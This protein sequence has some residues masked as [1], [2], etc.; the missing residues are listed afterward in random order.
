MSIA[1]NIQYIKAQLPGNVRLVCVSKFHPV[2]A[3]QE[4]YNAGQRVF[5]ESKVQEMDEKHEAL[6]KDIEWHFIG[7][8]QSNKIKYIVPYVTLIHGVDSK[9]LLIE[10]NKQAEKIGRKVNCLLQVYIAQEE[11]KFGFLSEEVLSM[12]ESNTLEELPYVSVCGLMGMASNTDDSGQIKKEFRTLKNLFDKIKAN[13]PSVPGSFKELSMGM[14]ADYAFAVD[15]GSSLVRI[16]SA[17]FGSRL[18]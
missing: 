10:I 13:Y 3:L 17:I 6:P 12:F 1:S 11:T 7:H 4:A 5:G 9:K 14:S 16:G 8:L 2:E 15:E 18:Y